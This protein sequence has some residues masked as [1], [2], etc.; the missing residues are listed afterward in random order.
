MADATFA[1]ILVDKDKISGG[2]YRTGRGAKY[3]SASYITATGL[4]VKNVPVTNPCCSAGGTAGGGDNGLALD[5]YSSHNIFNTCVISNN[6]GD[7]IIG[8]GWGETHN[9]FANCTVANNGLYQV[10]LQD[11]NDS[12]TFSG[13]SYTGIS[14]A[15]GYHV[16]GFASLG[17]SANNIYVHDVLRGPGDIGIH[18]VGNNGCL[19]NNTFISGT[20]AVDISLTGTNNLANGNFTPDGTVPGT[21]IAGA[22]GS[23]PPTNLMVTVQ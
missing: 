11:T 9:T 21:L 1:N 17:G 13:G 14:G 23:A 3:D 7:G 5:H 20:L 4:T 6:G 22:C 18:L 10:F 19:N 15:G 2:S 16:M 8:W 12:W